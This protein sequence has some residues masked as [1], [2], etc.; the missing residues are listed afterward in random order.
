MSLVKSD[1]QKFIKRLR[2]AH[3][4]FHTPIKYYAVGEY[5]GK[6]LRPHYHIIL[7]NARVELVQG[8]W[9]LGQIHY[10]TVEG[11]SIGYCLKYISKPRR[12]PIHAN[13]DRVPEFALISQGL[14]SNYLTDAMINFHGDDL[15]NRMYCT[16][17]DGK[18]ISMPRYY[19]DKLYSDEE[20]R[21]IGEA[22]QVKFEADP[23]NVIEDPMIYEQQVKAAFEK[24]HRN[25]IKNNKI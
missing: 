16:I 17:E 25:S 15:L 1:V 13:D 22:Y 19:K 23:N 6:T 24:M 10:G 12:I 9:S 20:R 14:G 5:G 11:A 21:L 8:A 18:K 7:Y 2:K 4:Q 3:G